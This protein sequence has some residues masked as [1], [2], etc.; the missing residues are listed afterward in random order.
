MCLTPHEALPDPGAGIVW[1]SVW[2]IGCAY[3]K[4]YNLQKIA[5]PNGPRLNDTRVRPHN[6]ASIWF[7]N[8]F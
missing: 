3:D 2:G 1:F 6:W 5:I 8:K 7:A 4:A